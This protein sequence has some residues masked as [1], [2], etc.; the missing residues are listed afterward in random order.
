MKSVYD[1]YSPSLCFYL[2]AG[3]IVI[4]FIMDLKRLRAY[5][6]YIYTWCSFIGSLAVFMYPLVTHYG[7]Y[8]FSMVLYESHIGILFAQRTTVLADVIGMKKMPM[9]FGFL[10]TVNALGIMVGRAIGGRFIGS[11]R[12]FVYSFDVFQT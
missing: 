2:L 3:R 11:K 6:L 9:M 7:W 12:T 1:R 5:R 8:T 4:G 10:Q